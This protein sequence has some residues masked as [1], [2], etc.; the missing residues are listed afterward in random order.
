MTATSRVSTDGQV[1]LEQSHLGKPCAERHRAN[2]TESLSGNR[3]DAMAKQKRAAVRLADTDAR[4][5]RWLHAWHFWHS[6]LHDGRRAPVHG[7]AGPDAIEYD[8]GTRCET[9]RGR[10]SAR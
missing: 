8:A 5:L 2:Q 1:P 7:P 9:P 10:K 3:Q 4:G 6:R